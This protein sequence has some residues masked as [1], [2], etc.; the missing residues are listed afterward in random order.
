MF[1]PLLSRP[2]VVQGR[3]KRKIY[4]NVRDIIKN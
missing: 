2:Q 3:I 1:P 4:E